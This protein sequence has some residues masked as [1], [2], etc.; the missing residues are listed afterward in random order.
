MDTNRRKLLGAFH[1]NS[2]AALS[3][4]FNYDIQFEDHLAHEEEKVLEFLNDDNEITIEYKRKGSVWAI[5]TTD[6][7]S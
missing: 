4:S 2:Y 5:T 3:N 1:V 6:K 7:Q